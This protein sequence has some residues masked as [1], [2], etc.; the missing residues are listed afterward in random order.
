MP[1]LEEEEDLLNKE[2]PVFELELKDL[3]V[4]FAAF[5]AFEFADNDDWDG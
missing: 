1:P 5:V 2:R 4:S 3:D